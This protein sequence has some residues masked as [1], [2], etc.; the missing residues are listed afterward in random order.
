MTSCLMLRLSSITIASSGAFTVTQPLTSIAPAISMAPARPGCPRFIGA[1][2]ATSRREVNFMNVIGHSRFLGA[3]YLLHLPEGRMVEKSRPAQGR[4][5]ESHCHR[6][7]SS[8]AFA[9]RE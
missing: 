9:D 7:R 5:A 4:Y 1:L 6:H 2:C 3:E 8:R